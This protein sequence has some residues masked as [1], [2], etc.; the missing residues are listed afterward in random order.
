MHEFFW[1]SPRQSS[2]ILHHFA[3]AVMSTFILFWNILLF[4]SVNAPINRSLANHS[5]IICL[6]FPMRFHCKTA[7]ITFKVKVVRFYLRHSELWKFLN[8][9]FRHVLERKHMAY[10]TKLSMEHPVIY[11]SKSYLYI[12]KCGMNSCGV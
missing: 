9:I 2:C 12:Q 6:I 5:Q 11:P 10:V 7:K 8:I 1:T 4:L 3:W